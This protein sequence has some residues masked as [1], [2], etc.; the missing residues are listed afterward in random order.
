[1]YFIYHNHI[2]TLVNE[3]IKFVY[4]YMSEFL[5]LSCKYIRINGRKNY[6]IWQFLT[7]T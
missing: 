1:M 7:K 4:K 3:G 6:Y 2:V 5:R